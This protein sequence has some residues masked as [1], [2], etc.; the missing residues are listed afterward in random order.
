MNRVPMNRGRCLVCCLVLSGAG[1]LAVGV[2]LWP[3]IARGLFSPDGELRP[4]TELWLRRYSTLLIGLACLALVAAALAWRRRGAVDGWLR[5]RETGLTRA[6]LLLASSV[7]ALLIAEGVIRALETVGA[8]P[9]PTAPGHVGAANDEF[10]RDVHPQL[11]ARGYRGAPIET[12]VVEGHRRI[13]L[14]GDSFVFGVGI[15]ELADTLPARLEAALRDGG[16]AD[17]TVY[18]G[19]VPGGDT[20]TALR[21]TRTLA[22]RVRPHVVVYIYF[23]NDVERPGDR[24]R[25]NE[26]GRLIPVFSNYLCRASHLWSHAENRLIRWTSGAGAV[27]Q[28]V[29]YLDDAYSLSN[30]RRAEHRGELLALVDQV[31]EAGAAPAVAIMP[32]IED[33]VDY[34]IGSAHRFVAE[35]C[36]EQGVPLIDL[37]DL[38][39]GED[40]ATLQVS[41][42]DHHLNERGVAR[43]AAAVAAFLREQ[44]L[45]E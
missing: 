20:L 5:G 29:R 14:V 15:R 25:F 4:Y 32:M 27:G 31:R 2:V 43:A 10:R 41:W 19:G 11:G 23:P 8:V 33:L 30:P 7:L 13:L 36:A 40:A 6:A 17:V 24:D 16:S 12:G 18:N 1:L 38:F 21:T 28:Y 22:P 39:R 26:R 34:P 45:V 35:V 42:R 3:A 44:G 37:L 9:A